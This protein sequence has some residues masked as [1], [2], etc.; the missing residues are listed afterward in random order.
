MITDCIS[1]FVIQILLQNFSKQEKIDHSC[2]HHSYWAPPTL[3]VVSLHQTVVLKFSKRTVNFS[4]FSLNLKLV[5]RFLISCF[6][7]DEPYENLRYIKPGDVSVWTLYLYWYCGGGVQA[8]VTRANRLTGSFCCD[9]TSWAVPS[10][11]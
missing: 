2:T 6:S 9:H 4:K 8:G 5:N 1:S 11:L 7:T 10:Q 3:L